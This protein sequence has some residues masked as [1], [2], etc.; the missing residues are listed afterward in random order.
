MTTH[1]FFSIVTRSVLCLMGMV[2]GISSL[3]A[4]AAT[5][6]VL[7]RVPVDLSRP[8][9][10]SRE[11]APE[12]S[13]AREHFHPLHLSPEFWTSWSIGA[14]V[15]AVA[16]D[17]DFVWIG[18]TQGVIRFAPKDESQT[19]FST[20]DGLMST[21]ILTIQPDAS[22]PDSSSKSRGTWFG[23]YGGG[24]THF[25][26][27]LWKTYT[28]YGAGLTTTYGPNW[29]LFKPGQ[30]L[31]DLWIYDLVFDTDGQMW[32]ATWKG[33]S[34]L[35]GRKFTTFTQADGL[36]DDWVYSMTIDRQG[37]FWFG[38]EGGV[39]HYNGKTWK[40]WTHADGLGA[41]METG[42]TELQDYGLP[43]PKHHQQQSKEVMT[44]N[45]NYVLCS[46]I[47]PEGH[48][49]FGT[50]G[51]GLARFDGKNWKNYTT[52]DGLAGNTVNSLAMDQT[53]VLWIATDRGVSRM[54]GQGF[55]NYNDR[56]GLVS[57]AVYSIAID[58]HN[59]K[60]FGAF[61]GITRYTGP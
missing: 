2:W 40:S 44:Y 16:V 38:T 11:T 37:D 47:G 41:R 43:I 18:T 15:R 9:L 57:D 51:A 20:K 53:G 54:D 7:Q 10:V 28:P 13:P 4:H 49:W 46:V 23:T 39:T 34:R 45:P 5:P 6:L 31:G 8:I 36:V 12:N 22:T 50:W 27:S 21:I 30:G 25:D 33:V 26:G 58:D 48:V 19:I 42:N 59:H 24:L 56:T 61:G 35:D 32:V 29:H 60:W 52:A 1:H 17:P 3:P 55:T 14:L